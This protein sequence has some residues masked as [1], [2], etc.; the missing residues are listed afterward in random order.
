VLDR[1]ETNPPPAPVA[2]SR[3]A[4]RLLG[5]AL[6]AA[7]WAAFA[8]LLA[9]NGWCLWADWS[10]PD[11]A[12]IDARIARGQHAE[13]EPE[14]RRLLRSSPEDG[15]ARMKLARLLAIR[16]D[17]PACGR[18]LHQVPAWSPRKAEALFLEGQ[19]Y[20]QLDRARDAE[21]AWKALLADD[22]LH[23]VPKRYSHG[24]ARD[25]I[26]L[27]VVERRLPEIREVILR[28]YDTAD[29]SERPGVLLQRIRAELELVAH[30]E[31][32][33]KL[34]QYVA[35]DPDDWEARRA[36]GFE[37][38][39]LGDEAAADRDLQ[40][41]LEAR[42]ADVA[43][44]RD[45]LKILA[46]RGDTAAIKAAVERLPAEADGD[47]HLWLAR[48]NVRQLDGDLAGAA[49]AFR[50]AVKL[51]PYLPEAHYKLGQA[52]QVLGDADAARLHRDRSRQ[53][54]R[55]LTDL[56]PAYEGVLDAS[57][58][59]TPDRPAYEAAVRRLSDVC[60]D[61]G[62]AKESAAW[63]RVLAGG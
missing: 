42:P 19:V 41:C 48:G 18:E 52:E 54:Y 7:S 60:R 59:A 13:A 35:A 45:W 24:A 57:Q 31:A 30:P 22:P 34:R 39:A 47:A 6:G 9:W 11:P 25:L 50:Q 33:A 46:E 40:A 16:G 38:H 61:L 4:P 29:T 58:K 36:L 43:A 28:V 5:R 55:V 63:L 15:E 37:E 56:R 17:R 26:G 1:L 12:A 14:L 20:K 2:R 10:P 53:L 62:W 21:P 51:D 44:W 49:E 27:Y 8:L 32:A 3:R 23:P